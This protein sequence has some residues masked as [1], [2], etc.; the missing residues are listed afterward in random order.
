MEHFDIKNRRKRINSLLLCFLS[1]LLP[2]IELTS[3]SPRSY[4][5][6]IFDLIVLNYWELDFLAGV[7][8]HNPYNLPLPLCNNYVNCTFVYVLLLH[9]PCFYHLF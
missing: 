1:F 3:Q 8:Q 6:C 5:L 7:I 9:I 2:T 4:L